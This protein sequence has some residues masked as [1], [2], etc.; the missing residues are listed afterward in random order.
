[1]T[2]RTYGNLYSCMKTT[3][4]L[5]DELMIEVKT[6]AAV[7]RTTI[8]EIVERALRRELLDPQ[9]DATPRS[10][11]RWVTV[12]GG[13]PPGTDVSDRQSLRDWI[14]SERQS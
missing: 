6:A 9:P 13:L 5:P 7:R 4:E 8:R 2:D 11:I 12:D 10:P 3:V 1:M 14:D